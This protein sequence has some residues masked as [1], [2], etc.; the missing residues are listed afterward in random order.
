M[1]ILLLNLIYVAI[2]ILYS[3]MFK[4]VKKKC[5]QSKTVIET[6]HC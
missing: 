4:R 3:Y 5:K 1:A 2:Y 6:H